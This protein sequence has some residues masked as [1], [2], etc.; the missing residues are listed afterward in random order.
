MSIFQFESIGQT[1]NQD[2]LF[3]YWE[4]EELPDT[5]RL[6]AINA[7]IQ[8]NYLEIQPDNIFYLAQLQYAFAEKSGLTSYV[9]KAIN[10]KGSVYRVLGDF[11]SAIKLHLKA[12]KI[13]KSI[14]CQEGTYESVTNL[15]NVFYEKQDYKNATFYLKRASNQL[16]YWEIK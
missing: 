16:S 5:V 7:F 2:S 1:I 8:N 11:E 9:A 4:D 6:K 15:G 3:S 12:L 13:C 10:S 14:S